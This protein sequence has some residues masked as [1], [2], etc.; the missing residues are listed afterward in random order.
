MKLANIFDNAQLYK[1]FQFA[2]ISNGSKARIREE[3]LKPVGV[4]KVLDFGCG[5]GYHSEDF[6]NSDY[7]GIE[8]LA[9][10]VDKANRMYKRTGISFILGDHLSLKSIPDSSFDLVIAIGVLHHI[11]NQFFL[12]LLERH[13]EF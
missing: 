9:S 13:I 4:N 3:V 8:P 12:N 1:L 11:D 7:L 5:I 2:V 10:C 6:R